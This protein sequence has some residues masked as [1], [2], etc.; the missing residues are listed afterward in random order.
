MKSA[1]NQKNTCDRE[2][3]SVDCVEEACY[4]KRCKEK[5]VEARGGGG[6]PCERSGDAHH[7]SLQCKLQI[8]VSLRVSAIVL[9]IKVSFRAEYKE[10]KKTLSLVLMS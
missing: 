8:L 4:K 5:W 7:L 3:G 9:A 1:V 10:I 2:E 6:F